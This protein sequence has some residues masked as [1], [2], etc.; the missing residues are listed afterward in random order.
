MPRWSVALA[1]AVAMIV[2]SLGAAQ[3]RPDS[4]RRDTLRTRAD[5]L[6]ADSLAG[7]DSLG[8]PRQK[9]ELVKWVETD[10]VMQALMER[11]GYSVTRYQGDRVQFVAKERT[12]IIEGSPSAVSRDDALLVGDS[13]QYNDST[14]RLIARG[15]TLVLRDPAQGPDDVR[16]SGRIEYDVA[17]R[18]GLVTNVNTAI[19]SGQR[20]IVH[21]ERAGFR[22]DSGPNG[23]VTSLYARH[24]WITSC[25]ETE[26]H[27]HFASSEMKLIAKNILVARPAVLYIAD[28]PVLWLPFIFQDIRSGRR[29]GLLMPNIGFSTLIRSNPNEQRIVE[30]LGYYF[31]LNDFIDAQVTT[32]WLSGARARNGFPGYTKLNV[33]SRYNWRDRFIDGRIG[34][35][36]QWLRDGSTN[37]Q[38]S[39]SHA[40]RFSQ[41]TQLT[42]NMNYVTNTRAQFN[43]TYNPYVPN[44]TIRSSLSFSSGRGPFNL[45]LGGTQTQYPGRDQLDRD[46]PSLN[47]TAK[48]IRLGEWLT[49][50]PVF[51]TQ[52]RQSFD[53]DLLS[54][55]SFVFTPRPGGGLDSARVRQNNRSTSM[56]FDTPLE[57]FGFSWRNSFRLTDQSDDYPQKVT[58]SDPADSS[59]REL[60]VF[61]RTFATNLDWDTGINLPQI[62]QGSWNIQPRITIQNVDSRAGFLTR[63]QFTGGGWVAQ[64]KRLSYG[65]GASPSVYARFGGFGPVAAFRHQI[66]ATLGYDYAPRDSVDD[67]FLRAV[68]ATRAGYNAAEPQNIVSLGLTTNI[69]AKLRSRNDTATV[70][71]ARKI[72]I[73][74]LTLTTLQWD[75]ERA[76]RGLTGL[77][78]ETFDY[79]V[80]SDLLP[81]FD[82]QV[83]YDLFQGETSNDSAQFKPFQ[84]SIRGS[85]SLDKNS[86]IVLGLARL[87]GID[88][89]SDAIDTEP[90]ERDTGQQS[91]YGRGSSQQFVAGQSLGGSLNRGSQ[92]SIPQGE[93][94]RANLT[95]SSTRD[96]PITGT[97]VQVLN[98]AI[99]C[100]RLRA[101]PIGYD[102]CLRQ[103][104]TGQAGSNPFNPVQ[105]GTIYVS[106][107]QTNLSG[108]V[109]FH[110]TP[111]WGA[112]WQTNYDAEKARFGSHIISLQRELHDWNAIFAFTQAPNG[113]AAFNFLITLKAQ[114]DIKL[115]FNRRSNRRDDT[116][117]R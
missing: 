12:L 66:Q 10:S 54:P 40:Q 7:R 43:S 20:W 109:S 32:D 91:Q 33:E 31:V 115:D 107:P 24:G 11:R 46:F 51:S 100:E 14:Q 96:R 87:L 116:I 72:K 101:N 39:L 55:Q 45:S 26:P 85:L 63:S 68:N 35:S 70:D 29:S 108:T 86:G 19:E 98:P 106:P 13:I 28:I 44:S 97:N 49:W 18:R 41:R 5:S 73:L 71:N 78:N 95:F 64:K 79:T 15:D 17:N 36:M 76:K 37:K 25:E 38:Y 2:P 9:A 103:F 74:Q 104:A 30:G 94:W 75:F 88:I 61:R 77:T 99:E 81:G 47:I 59:R 80:R 113:N 57:I 84:T 56:S 93:G 65:V 117:V 22:S 6:R 60:R 69:E 1:V 92:L 16:A 58:L 23:V 102:A 27:Y 111:K 52:T 114:P 3:V 48:P 4:V 50:T 89:G 34:A 105:G 42:A 82:F 21:G 90:Q 83:G 67:D 110:L 8:R 112:Q 62:L 53:I